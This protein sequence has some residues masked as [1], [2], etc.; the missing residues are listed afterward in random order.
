MAAL[1]RSPRLGHNELMIYADYPYLNFN[2]KKERLSIRFHEYYMDA[3]RQCYEQVESLNRTDDE[4]KE[5]FKDLFVENI[6]LISDEIPK[7]EHFDFAVMTVNGMIIHRGTIMRI[8]AESPIIQMD[9]EQTPPI[10]ITNVNIV[11]KPDS[12]PIVRIPIEKLISINRHHTMGSSRRTRRSKR[13]K[14]SRRTRRN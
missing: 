5:L 8:E 7:N 3:L 9:M 6:R 1:K 4:K 2:K 10:S 14:R 13:S 12:G 11:I